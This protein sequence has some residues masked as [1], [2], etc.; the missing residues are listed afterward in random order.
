MTILAAGAALVASVPSVEFRPPVVSAPQPRWTI[1]VPADFGAPQRADIGGNVVVVTAQWGLMAFDRESGDRLWRL[2][3]RPVLDEEGIYVADTDTDTVVGDSFIFR[4]AYLGVAEGYDQVLDLRTGIERWT[5]YAG[6]LTFGESSVTTLDCGWDLYTPCTLAAHTL[7]TGDMLWR[8]ETPPASQRLQREG[9]GSLIAFTDST[10]QTITTFDLTSGNQLGRWP[11][12]PTARSAENEYLIFD[13][14]LLYEGEPGAIQGIDPSNGDVLWT[15][16]TEADYSYG[17]EYPA[18]PVVLN[19]RLIDEPANDGQSRIIDLTTGS[20]A[21]KPCRRENIAYLGTDMVLEL[22]DHRGIFTATSLKT[23]EPHWQST[24]EAERFG[25]QQ[26]Y[27]H[28]A[29]D[30][31]IVTSSH[32]IALGQGENR[33]FF[34]D[35]ATGTSRTLTDM[36]AI[37]YGDGAMAAAGPDTSAQVSLIELDDY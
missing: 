31:W 24:I 6:V 22:D 21:P 13:G 4:P 32:P 2:Y 15:A 36:Q 14:R 11:T 29:D 7:T 3:L 25:G 27:E 16:R 30:T 34:L 23:G 19:G 1:D 10:G 5:S 33:L 28:H 20:V 8:V 9:D 18:N 35:L 17:A 26:I 37:G 12:E